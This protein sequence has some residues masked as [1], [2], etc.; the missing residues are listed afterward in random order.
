MAIKNDIKSIMLVATAKLGRVGNT[1]KPAAGRQA[2][3]QQAHVETFFFFLVK[4]NAH[5][6]ARSLDPNCHET[7][8]AQHSIMYDVSFHP[9]VFSWFSS[10]LKMG[11]LSFSPLQKNGT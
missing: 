5:S 6:L 2:G 7:H 10:V 4:N 8:T 3:R 1:A 11:C 9:A